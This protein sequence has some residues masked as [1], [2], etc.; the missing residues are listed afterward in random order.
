MLARSATSSRPWPWTQLIPLLGAVCTGCGAASA[1]VQPGLLGLPAAS[2]D[3]CVQSWTPVAHW[4]E[5]TELGFSAV[6]VLGRLAGPRSSPL[7]WAEPVPNEEYVLE[8][9]PERGASGIE[10]DVQARDGRLLISQSVPRYDAPEGTTCPPSALQIPV[11]VTLRSSG[12]ALDEQFD[13]ML[14]ASEPYRGRIRHTL[15]TRAL[16]GGLSFYQVLSLDPERSFWIGSLGVELLVWE[17]GSLGSMSA[18]VGGGYTRRVE[19]LRALPAPAEQSPPLATW[20]SAQ[21]CEGDARYL[22]SDARVLGFSVRDVLE[23]LAAPSARSLTWSDGSVVPVAFE[24]EAP[25]EFS[26]Q[27][28]GEALRFSAVLRAR[29]DDQSLDVRLPVQIEVQTRGGDIGAIAIESSEPETPQRIVEVAAPHP[30][31]PLS[32]YRALLVSLDWTRLGDSDTGS[33]ALRGVESASP[34]AEGRY[35]SSMLTNGRW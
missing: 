30:R 27:E 16:H 2:T 7:E 29:S 28:I 3:P 31:L 13:T 22:P 23:R 33:L 6:E 5:P 18:E 11:E 24:L 8:Y 14:E 10:V 4:D 12:Q 17:N 9:G 34:D 19:Q 20:P 26:C 21:A 25:P 1:M 32:G 15:S 35:P